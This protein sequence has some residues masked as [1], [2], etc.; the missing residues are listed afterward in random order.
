MKR[1]RYMVALV[2]GI[3][4]VISL[5]TN[6]IGPLIPDMI[7]SFRISLAAA[8]LLPFAFFI[9]YGVMSI[10]AGMLIEAYREKRIILA[11]FTASFAGAL[12]FALFP[13]YPVAMGSFFVIGLAM[14][15]LQVAI[16]PLLRVAGGEE[17][18]AFNSAFAQLVFG[19]ASFLSPLIYSYLV[20][21]LDSRS[22][23]VLAALASVVPPALPWASLYWVFAAVT[24]LTILLI[25]FTNIPKVELTDEERVGTWETHRKLFR[26]PTVILYFVSMFA[27]VGTE[28]G[29]ADWIS[30][31]LS[32][33]HGYDPQTAGAAAVAW[34]W[35][36]LTA[37]CLLGML[38]LRLFDSRKVL[39][40]SAI[41]AMAVLTTALLGP[42]Q[43]ALVAFPMVG[44]AI[45]VMWPII[46]SLGLNSVAEHHGAVS[47]IL[48]TAICGGA[49]VP[50]IIGRLGDY[51]GLRIGM[52]FLYVTLAWILSI[53]FWARPIIAN[54][55]FALAQKSGT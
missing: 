47:G 49:V 16:N 55:T 43:V 14:A 39:I 45:S 6:I 25:A 26:N 41:F 29:T 28:Q 42:G 9:A 3:F 19:S 21:N 44:F 51:A 36:L 5:L 31:F 48:C 40:V 18:Y 7:D 50:L 38:L 24:L 13:V 52:M 17:N 4:F 2:L 46:M 23:P 32:T 53:G 37:G 34:F 27:Y 22:N 12:A 35:G 8:G 54:K 10:P 30:K 1:S 11:A 20:K 33:Y 15:M